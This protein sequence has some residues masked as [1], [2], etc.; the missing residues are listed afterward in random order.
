MILGNICLLK[1]RKKLEQLLFNALYAVLET[2]LPYFRIIC[3]E[4]YAARVRT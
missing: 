3:R 2:L 1:S 4:F